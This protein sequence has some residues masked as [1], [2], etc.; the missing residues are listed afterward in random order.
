MTLR[1]V[2]SP[3]A[4]APTPLILLM[5]LPFLLHA[6]AGLSTPFGFAI[7]LIALRLT[8]GQRP[9]LPKRIQRLTILSDFSR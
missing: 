4:D 7:M 3:C 1:A 9:W 2:P 6:A 5:T 8:L